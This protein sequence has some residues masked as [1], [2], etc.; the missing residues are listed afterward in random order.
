MSIAVAAKDREAK[1]QKSPCWWLQVQASTPNS[2]TP[3]YSPAPGPYSSG[4]TWKYLQE[5]KIPHLCSSRIVLSSLNFLPAVYKGI[6]VGKKCKILLLYVSP[7]GPRAHMLIKFQDGLW[8][9]WVPKVQIH[10]NGNAVFQMGLGLPRRLLSCWPVWH[11]PQ[12][13]TFLPF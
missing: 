8:S 10:L 13:L 9:P 3:P 7:D 4:N 6:L 12:I 1:A 11:C 5:K 2:W